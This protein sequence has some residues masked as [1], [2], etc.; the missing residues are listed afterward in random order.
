MVKSRNEILK[1]NPVFSHHLLRIQEEKFKP[2]NDWQIGDSAV[3]EGD[4]DTTVLTKEIAVQLN[5][6]DDAYYEANRDHFEVLINHERIAEH[7]LISAETSSEKYL[8]DIANSLTELSQQYGDLIMLGDWNTLWSLH[9]NNNKKAL[10][11]KAYFFKSI[12]PSFNGGFRLNENEINEFIPHLFWLTRCYPELPQL[13]IGFSNSNTI[14]NICRYGV[15]HL[16]FY[17][18]L[19]QPE[20]LQFL[21]ERSYIAVEHSIEPVT[22]DSKV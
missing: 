16:D 14:F 11:A 1:V 3:L 8:K 6:E 2:D 22:F 20:V 17:D 9:Q 12:D 4:H 7:K 5:K 18:E 21:S 10:E 19:E 13:H 15:L